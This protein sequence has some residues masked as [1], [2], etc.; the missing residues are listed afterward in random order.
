MTCCTEKMEEKNSGKALTWFRPICLGNKENKF[1]PFLALL[2]ISP[3]H[4]LISLTSFTGVLKPIRILYKTYFL[5]KQDFMRSI[6][7]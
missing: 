1:L 6:N 4:I 3:A 2:C 7:S 5:N